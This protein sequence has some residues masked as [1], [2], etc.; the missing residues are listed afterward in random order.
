[1]WFAAWLSVYDVIFGLIF[2]YI[3]VIFPFSAGESRFCFRELGG[4]MAEKR[5]IS[6]RRNLQGFTELVISSYYFNI[7]S[8]CMCVGYYIPL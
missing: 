6:K 3:G 2:Y 1:M 4:Y 5:R 8:V 7:V